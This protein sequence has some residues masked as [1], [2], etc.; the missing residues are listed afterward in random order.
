VVPAGEKACVAGFRFAHRH[1]AV[2]AAVHEHA[3]LPV[4][5]A[6]HHHR[7]AADAGGAVIAGVR[8]LCLVADAQPGPVED[9]RHLLLEDGG[10]RVDGAVHALALHQVG[11][12]GHA[13]RGVHGGVSG[14]RTVP[15]NSTRPLLIVR[16]VRQSMMGVKPGAN[17]HRP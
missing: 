13:V 17:P 6:H 10:V 2:A 8:Q 12:V 5:T 3:H 14:R 16:S 7:L 4:V 11:V 1:A 15:K 9:A